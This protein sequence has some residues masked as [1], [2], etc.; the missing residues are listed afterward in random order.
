M[1]VLVKYVQPGIGP[2]DYEALRPVVNWEADPPPG[3]LFHTV[4][5]ADGAIHEYDVWEDRASF[6]RFFTDRFEAALAKNGVRADP[7]EIIELYNAAA[8]DEIVRLITP[9]AA[10]GLTS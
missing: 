8:S 6:D 2:A 7:P 4:W 3:G 9:P 10:A 5:F 1:P